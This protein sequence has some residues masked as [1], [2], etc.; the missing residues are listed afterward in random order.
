MRTLPRLFTVLP[1]LDKRT[2]QVAQPASA[3]PEGDV[4]LISGLGRSLGGGNGNLL[5]FSHLENPMDRGTWQVTVHSITKSWTPLSERV[6]TLRQAL[7][8]T[9][10]CVYMYNST[11]PIY[12]L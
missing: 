11:L 3:E 4:G 9:H 1:H 6:C 10:V 8:H 5:Q 2:S 7:E 12:K